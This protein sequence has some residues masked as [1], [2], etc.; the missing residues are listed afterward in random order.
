MIISLFM[1]FA[2][3]VPVLSAWLLAVRRPQWRRR[4]VALTAA[5]PVP[6]CIAALVIGLSAGSIWTDDA[7][8]LLVLVQVIPSLVMAT[9]LFGIGLALAVLGIRLAG[10][11]G[12]KADGLEGIFE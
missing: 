7:D 12:H 10:R 5:L 9:L 8:L 2:V 6:V 4:R 11:R 1:L 3:V